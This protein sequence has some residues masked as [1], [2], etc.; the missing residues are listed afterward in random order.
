M[1]TTLKYTNT[2]HFDSHTKKLQSYSSVAKDQKIEESYTYNSF[3]QILSMKHKG[4]YTNYTKQFQYELNGNFSYEIKYD[5]SSLISK[6]SFTK[7]NEGLIT[8]GITH[9][10][11]VIKNGLVDQIVANYQVENSSVETYAYLNQLVV[12]KNSR[13]LDVTYDYNQNNDV[14]YHKETTHYASTKT[15]TWKYAYVYDKYGNWIISVS[16]LHVSYA[17]GVPSFPNPTLRKITYSN[18]ET[19]G[20]DD[21]TRLEVTNHLKE[22]RNQLNN[23][24]I[25]TASWKRLEQNR[26]NFYIDG[27]VVSQEV[28]SGFMWLSLLVFHKPSKTLFLCEEYAKKSPNEFH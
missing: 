16:L 14:T 28:T 25:K 11:I 13:T 7:T 6:E 18:G 23:T 3:G 9:R 26:F 8:D 21:L 1:L 20:F 24:D 27:K 5:E 4:K 15:S 10:K 19:T 12:R 22:L 17:P 2:L